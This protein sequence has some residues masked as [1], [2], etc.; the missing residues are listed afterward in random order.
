MQQNLVIAAHFTGLYDVNRNVTLN[1]D[2]F[3]II[4]DWAKSVYDLQL[5]GIIFHNNFSEQTCKENQNKY[6]R[7]IKVDYNKKFKPNVYRYFVYNQFL[8]QQAQSIKNIFFTDVSDVIV[9]RNP[10][11]ETLYLKNSEAIFCGD[12]PEILDNEWMRNHSKHLRNQ[13]SDY[14][15][16]ES[17][18]KEQ[19]LLNCGIIG[20]TI[21][22][23]KPF[24]EKLWAIHQQFNCGNETLYTGDMGAFNYLIRTQFN[25][26]II[27][28]SPVN[29]EFKKYETETS[30][31]FKHK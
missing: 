1:D 19:T 12:E 10:F 26:K 13:I 25:N 22:T 30:C 7:F 18:F 14:A 3:S 16:F 15:I 29:T 4:S 11:L 2:D 9:L 21:N 23:M 8:K 6:I 31:W 24:I 27:H 28:G 5:Q 17:N 20:G